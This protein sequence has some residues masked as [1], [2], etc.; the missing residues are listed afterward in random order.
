MFYW[1]GVVVVLWAVVGLLN[2]L[3]SPRPDQAAVDQLT[4]QITEQMAAEEFR[5]QSWIVAERLAAEACRGLQ[6]AD[7]NAQAALRQLEK[8]QGPPD[9][10]ATIEEYRTR[11]RGS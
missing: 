10:R 8:P 3:F 6:T 2:W 9:H 7:R 5:R 11:L 4:D 1:I